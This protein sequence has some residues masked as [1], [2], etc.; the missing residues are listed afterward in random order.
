MRVTL[1]FEG[2]KELQKQLEALADETEIRKTNQAIYQ[3]CA[4]ATEPRM[5]RGQCGI[6]EER[7][8]AARPRKGQ[9]AEESHRK[10]GGSRV[11][12]AGR[13]R[14]LVLHEVRGVGDDEA[15]AAGLHL[16]HAGRMRR[17]IFPDS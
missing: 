13:C 17:G 6:R 10:A 16:Q 7:L 12:A 3:R 2:L 1:E 11:V 8:Q 14:E 4:D 15:A 5:F 9:C